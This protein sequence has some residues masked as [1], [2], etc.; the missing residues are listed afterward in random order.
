MK[1]IPLKTG[2]I[3]L[4]KTLFNIDEVYGEGGSCIVYNGTYVDSLGALHNVRIKE[5]YPYSG[6]CFREPNNSISGISSSAK[7]RFMAASLKQ[8]KIQTMKGTVNSTAS[9]SEVIEANG[10]LY[11]ILD[12]YNGIRLD[13]VM[14][15]SLHDYIGVIAQIAE[16]IRIYH[17]N[18]YLHLDIKPENIFFIPSH[19]DSEGSVGKAVVLDFDSVIS[20]EDLNKEDV[21]ISYSD[22]YAAPELKYFFNNMDIS[23]KSDFYSVGVLLFCYI[24]NRLPES[25]DV[26]FFTEWKFDRNEPLLCGISELFFEKITDFFHKTLAVFPH[27]RYKND[28]ELIVALQELYELSVISTPYIESNINP[29]LMNYFSGRND[30]L[31]ELQKRISDNGRVFICGIGGVGKTSIAL[32]YA[33]EHHMDYDTIL[34]SNLKDDIYSLF[35]KNESIKFGNLPAKS[36]KKQIFCNICKSSRV[37]LIVDNYSGSWEDIASFA[38]ETLCDMIV[39]TRKKYDSEKNDVLI[40]YGLKESRELFDHYCKKNYNSNENEVIDKILNYIGNHT[41]TVELLAKLL[42]DTD[43]SPETVLERLTRYEIAEL[44]GDEIKNQKDFHFNSLSVNAHIDLLYDLSQFS[45]G[46]KFVIQALLLLYEDPVYRPRLM[47][48]CSLCSET[49]LNSLIY[50]GWISEN[51]SFQLLSLH[52]LIFDRCMLHLHPSV[53]ELDKLIETMI[54]NGAPIEIIDSRISGE[55]KKRTEIWFM[56][57][58]KYY[59]QID[60]GML[61]YQKIVEY[62][63][64]DKIDKRSIIVEAYPSFVDWKSSFSFIPSTDTTRLK[65]KKMVSKFRTLSRKP[66]YA[67]YEDYLFLGDFCNTHFGFFYGSLNHNIK[68]NKNGC[69]GIY[70]CAEKFYL[71]AYKVAVTEKE[72]EECARKLYEYYC[73]TWI[74]FDIIAKNPYKSSL[75]SDKYNRHTVGMVSS[76]TG[77]PIEKSEAEKELD[78]LGNYMSDKKI[79]KSIRY[80]RKIAKRYLKTGYPDFNSFVDLGFLEGALETPF[81]LKLLTKVMIKKGKHGSDLARIYIKRHKYNKALSEIEYA[82]KEMTDGSKDDFKTVLLDVMAL[83]CYRKG[84]Y[85]AEIEDELIDSCSRL[86]QLEKRQEDIW[87]SELLILQ[88]QKYLKASESDKASALMSAF[89]SVCD[90]SRS[91][92]YD[93]IYRFLPA[94]EKMEKRSDLL[95]WSYYRLAAV[96]ASSDNKPDSLNFLP[97]KELYLS[98]AQYALKLFGINDIRTIRMYNKALEACEGND[99][100]RKEIMRSINYE[101]LTEYDIKESFRP[102]EG[103]PQNCDSWLRCISKYEESGNTEKASEIMDRLK[104][105]IENVKDTD[106]SLYINCLMKLS[107]YYYGKKDKTNVKN[108]LSL[109]MLCI[110]MAND[111]MDN[112]GIIKVYLRTSNRLIEQNRLNSNGKYISD[113]VV[114]LKKAYKIIEENNDIDYYAAS[115]CELLKEADSENSEFYSNKLIQLKQISRQ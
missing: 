34:F 17:E 51:T 88:A 11:N 83:K 107:D 73:P 86:A 19:N 24:M 87:L 44:P 76:M 58:K 102:V 1:R 106:P 115:V 38:N 37:L 22:G 81:T 20:V 23:E 8:N 57:L 53:P 67:E 16:T 31:Q 25:C 40:L 18:G 71:S 49:D 2:K 62:Y 4:G 112:E 82:R 47:K 21:V 27:E 29:Y 69:N 100:D 48:I 43:I 89:A 36:D 5:L 6:A 91:L 26:D 10:T 110:E 84:E 72:I 79:I 50:K 33:E 80:A 68:R 42:R 32:K 65:Y 103:M 61:Y 12:Y 75:K 101:V 97:L 96:I 54:G 28:H 85:P 59:E 60:T 15:S 105:E 111:S 90:T 99:P 46:E 63:Q 74:E 92:Y 13:L 30:E 55:S 52:P 66:I 93:Y 64:K 98:A 78:L 9:I 39:T 113:A 7:D 14:F 95:E 109:D 41:L 94:Y 108:A 70:K 45:Y 104:A 3:S 35:S 56:L 114:L 77:R